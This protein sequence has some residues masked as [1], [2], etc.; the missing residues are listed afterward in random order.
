MSKEYQFWANERAE[1][2]RRFEDEQKET[3]ETLRP[4]QQELDRLQS[5]ILD[6]H[7]RINEKR[8][9]VLR[10]D[11]EIKDLIRSITSRQ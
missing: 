11:N 2:V 5:Q 4:L 9:A 1:L 8:S 10:N 7:Q 3:E 6:Y